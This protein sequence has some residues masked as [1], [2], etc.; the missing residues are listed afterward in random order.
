MPASSAVPTSSDAVHSYAVFVR[1]LLIAAPSV[2]S[3]S[4]LVSACAQKLRELGLGRGQRGIDRQAATAVL[5]DYYG[6]EFLRSADP[7][8]AA[9]KRGQ[10]FRMSSKSGARDVPLGRQL[11][12]AHFLFNDV[13][14]FVLALDAAVADDGASRATSPAARESGSAARKANDKVART[15]DDLRRIIEENPRFTLEDLWARYRGTLAR[16]LKWDAS[17]FE[18]VKALAQ[19]P[20][21]LQYT[22]TRVVSPHPRDEEFADRLRQAA[23]KLYAS[24]DRPTR[25]SKSA[26]GRA[27]KLAHI[28]YANSAYPRSTRV[29]GEFVESQWH[30][31]ARRYVWALAHAPTANVS[32]SRLLED[33][34]VWYYKFIEL[35]AY[36]RKRSL[37]PVGRLREGQIVAILREHSIDLKWEGPCPDK[38]FMK[39]GRAYVKRGLRPI[40]AASSEPQHNARSESIDGPASAPVPSKSGHYSAR[41]A[42]V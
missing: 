33:A 36:F 18:Q 42:G 21:R 17:A 31:Y 13:S 1:D 27:A 19:K 4:A 8:Y 23:L 20:R 29:L 37:P 16:L 11:L 5:E 34:G 10:W 38:T 12:T 14:R 40:G 6:E 26:I 3:L 22:P 28:A 15:I 39:S 25:I 30:F 35:D 7:A 41:L 24:T 2:Y 32:T 9:G